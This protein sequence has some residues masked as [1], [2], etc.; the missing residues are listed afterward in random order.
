M[1]SSSFVPLFLYLPCKTLHCHSVKFLFNKDCLSSL[2]RLDTELG[3]VNTLMNISKWIQTLVSSIT[4][5]Y[6]FSQIHLSLKYFNKESKY[7]SI[8]LR[9]WALVRQIWVWDS[10]SSWQLVCSW[11]FFFMAL[12]KYKIRLSKCQDRIDFFQQFMNWAASHL[13]NRKEFWRAEQ[14]GR[15]FCAE[16]R[17]E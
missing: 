3:A 15:I 1:L 16:T 2:Y 12:L 10:S 4:F 9:A 11:T 13:T 8:E 6:S 17:E 7:T 5:F 14:N